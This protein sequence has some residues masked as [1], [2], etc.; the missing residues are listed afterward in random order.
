[1]VGNLKGWWREDLNVSNPVAAATRPSCRNADISGVGPFVRRLYRH[2]PTP[3]GLSGSRR[4]IGGRSRFLFY[5][6][7][8]GVGGDGSPWSGVRRCLRRFLFPFDLRQRLLPMFEMPAVRPPFVFP[9]RVCAAL[10]DLF[11][12][13]IVT[14]VHIAVLYD[15]IASRG[16]KSGPPK[17]MESPARPRK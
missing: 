10:N 12:V 5:S 11:G 2:R 14:V 1:M 13:G 17:E 6:G 16:E 15:E 3:I 7:R 9:Y 4:Q 8:D